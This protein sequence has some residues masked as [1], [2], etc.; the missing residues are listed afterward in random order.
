MVYFRTYVSK[1][2]ENLVPIFKKTNLNIMQPIFNRKSCGFDEIFADCEELKGKE[3]LNVTKLKENLNPNMTHKGKVD[4][5]VSLSISYLFIPYTKYIYTTVWLDFNNGELV[6]GIFDDGLFDSQKY[7]EYYFDYVIK[8]IN[9]DFNIK[10]E[11]KVESKASDCV[12]LKAGDWSNCRFLDVF[13]DYKTEEFVS[14]M[15]YQ[16]V[17][18]QQYVIRNLTKK[19]NNGLK[20]LKSNEN[21]DHNSILLELKKGYIDYFVLGSDSAYHEDGRKSENYEVLYKL[22]NIEALNS[23]YL[24]LVKNYEDLVKTVVDQKNIAL[25]DTLNTIQ[26]SSVILTIVGWALVILQ[27][28][29]PSRVPIYIIAILLCSLVSIS[30]AILVKKVID[31]K[32]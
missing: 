6:K 32:K 24:N 27:H 18:A 30:I 17:V 23:E 11:I 1:A 14:W 12:S 28:D 31:K 15:H 19:V 7:I 8:M 16:N 26:I 22:F 2:E 21:V 5:E 10:N 20:S 13:T 4:F 9:A 29:L 25:G 3:Y